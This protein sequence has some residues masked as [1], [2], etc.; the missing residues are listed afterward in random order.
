MQLTHLGEVELQGVISGEGDVEAAVEV[1]LQR[2][3]VV[4]EEKGVVAKG[5][6][7]YADLSQVVQVLQHWHLCE[8]D[9]LILYTILIERS[10]VH[11]YILYNILKITSEHRHI[12][13]TVLI[14]FAYH[15]SKQNIKGFLLLH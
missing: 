4:V 6:H 7:C 3:A 8:E 13:Y 10:D 11:I 2:V 14:S 5:G 1:L 15:L 9:I 12:N